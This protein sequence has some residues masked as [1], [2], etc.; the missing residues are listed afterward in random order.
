MR[1][2]WGM[3]KGIN[4]I[5]TQMENFVAN[6]QSV[7]ACKRSWTNKLNAATSAHVLAIQNN[8]KQ[9]RERIF[10]YAISLLLIS[11]SDEIKFMRIRNL[12]YRFAPKNEAS[13]E[14]EGTWYW[15]NIIIIIIIMLWYERWGV[16]K[17]NNIELF[18]TSCDNAYAPWHLILF[19]HKNFSREFLIMI[20]I[21]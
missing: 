12:I 6:A 19:S 1:S 9:E 3:K 16:S 20:M 7:R 10:S 17:W 11:L 2:W 5:L 4:E 21:Q 14:L 18:L 8:T 15:K 13:E